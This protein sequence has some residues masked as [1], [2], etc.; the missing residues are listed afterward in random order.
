M[1]YKLV[2]GDRPEVLDLYVLP[3]KVVLVADDLPPPTGSEGG[4]FLGLLQA[5]LDQ[6]VAV[7]EEL[8]LGHVAQ[9]ALKR[10][11]GCLGGYN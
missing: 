5:A 11:G 2:L 4:H 10:G 3:V 1:T 6:G 9:H 8:L 7:T